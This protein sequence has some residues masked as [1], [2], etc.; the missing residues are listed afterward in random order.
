ML[1]HSE[2]PTGPTEGEWFMVQIHPYDKLYN[3]KLSCF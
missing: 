1:S 3:H 2:K